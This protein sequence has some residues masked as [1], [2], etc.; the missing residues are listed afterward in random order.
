MARIPLCVANIHNRLAC[1]HLFYIAGGG[2][3]PYQQSASCSGKG[4]IDVYI[5]RDI[6][7]SQPGTC[8]SLGVGALR[9][10]RRRIISRQSGV[11][12]SFEA[13][14]HRGRGLRKRECAR[15]LLGRHG[16]WTA[17]GA[18]DTN[19]PI[20]ICAQAGWHESRSNGPYG[21]WCRCGLCH[22]RLN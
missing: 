8:R 1:G 10:T 3:E 5:D 9:R 18:R 16:E 15:E 17:L 11:F 7:M 22:Q 13:S 20:L 6:P 2:A 19:S 4:T 12:I 21:S 14:R